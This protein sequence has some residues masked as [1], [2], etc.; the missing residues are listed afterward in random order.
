MI[1][2]REQETRSEVYVV[3]ATPKNGNAPF[4][5][6]VFQNEDYAI[7]HHQEHGCKSDDFKVTKETLIS[8]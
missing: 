3:T 1:D 8:L 2:R 7:E 6:G 5:Y 4:V